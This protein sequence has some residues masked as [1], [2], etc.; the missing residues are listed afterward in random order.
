MLPNLYEEHWL[1][2]TPRISRWAKFYGFCKSQL[3][4]ALS[5]S[6][7]LAATRDEFIDP[8]SVLFIIEI[9][10][11]SRIVRTLAT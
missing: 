2:N 6:T 11:M 9:Y 10:F 4:L 5:S 8:I 7:I 3:P 1:R